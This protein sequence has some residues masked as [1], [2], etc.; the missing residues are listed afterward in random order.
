MRFIIDV[1]NKVKK[2]NHDYLVIY[3]KITLSLYVN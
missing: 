3:K 1:I 2:H